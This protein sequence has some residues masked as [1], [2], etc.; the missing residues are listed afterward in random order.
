MRVVAEARVN[1]QTRRPSPAIAAWRRRAQGLQGEEAIGHEA[2]TKASRAEA[3]MAPPAAMPCRPK[4][5]GAPRA[6]AA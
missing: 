5:R 1:G 6:A 3:A 4:S 2:E